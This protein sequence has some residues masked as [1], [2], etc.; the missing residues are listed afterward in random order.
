MTA[1]TYALGTSAGGG[2]GKKPA[3]TAPAPPSTGNAPRSASWSTSKAS[4]DGNGG[5][6]AQTPPPPPAVEAEA[7]GSGGGGCIPPFV[8]GDRVV[9]KGYSCAGTVRFVGPHKTK[10]SMRCGIELDDAVGKND[11]TVGE[12]VYFSAKPNHGVLVVPDK[13]SQEHGGEAGGGGA[14]PPPPPQ[15][16]APPPQQQQQ[17]VQVQ[18]QPAR[19]ASPN[20]V[21]LARGFEGMLD[22]KCLVEGGKDSK[23][24]AWHTYYAALAG[25]TL[26]F[27][28]DEKDK[29]KGKKPQL[30]FPIAG[31]GLS[32]A[33]DLTKRSGAFVL[34]NATDKMALQPPDSPAVSIWAAALVQAGSVAKTAFLDTLSN[35]GAASAAASGSGGSSAAAAAAAVAAAAQDDGDDNGADGSGGGKKKKKKW[36]DIKSRLNKYLRARPA[37]EELKE[38]GIITDACFGGTIAS[39]VTFER[40]VSL[41][42]GKTG[43]PP[44]HSTLLSCSYLD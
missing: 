7:G 15:P 22:R 5:D 20:K 38:K 30:F 37:K 18:V 8:V 24:R 25:R 23:K 36:T 28:K 33:N 39:Q 32:S 12:D 35:D 9:V 41:P 14:G 3:R 13:C 31:S 43:A 19:A 40:G 42:E 10:G 21:M 27:F 44:V 11:G 1:P 2:G 26:Y 17:Q 6:A 34:G 16:A 4:G 29:K